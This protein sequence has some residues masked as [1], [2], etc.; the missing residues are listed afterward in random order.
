MDQAT[1]KEIKALTRVNA[2]GDAYALAAR[3]L[4]LTEIA[5]QFDSINR[6]HM[7]LG[8]LTWEL[9]HERYAVYEKLMA[10]A[11]SHMSKT[12]YQKFHMLF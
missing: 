8:Y 11:K 7:T 9:N 10:H 6:Q 4:G 5:E 12:D 3:A 1:V 2:H